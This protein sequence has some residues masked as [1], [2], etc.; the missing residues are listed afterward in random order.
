[1]RPT[2]GEA[3]ATVVSMGLFAAALWSTTARCASTVDF[4]VAAGSLNR[5]VKHG[6]GRRIDLGDTIADSQQKLRTGQRRRPHKKASNLARDVAEMLKQLPPHLRDISERMRHESKA[7]VAR[8]L[9]MTQ[10]AFYDVLA[11]I[12][13]RFEKAGMRDYLP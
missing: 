7:S 13:S 8:E 12:R 1:M 6:T 5:A 9:G 4:R 10:G 3:L 11:R 2:A